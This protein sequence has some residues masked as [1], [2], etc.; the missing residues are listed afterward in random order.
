MSDEFENAVPIEEVEPLEEN[1]TEMAQGTNESTFNEQHDEPEEIPSPEEV[2]DKPKKKKYTDIYSNKGKVLN[3]NRILSVILFIFV[4]FILFFLFILPIFKKEKKEQV[5]LDKA[6]KTYIPEVISMWEK[7]T[8]TPNTSTTDYQTQVFDDNISDEELDAIIAEIPIS[9][10]AQVNTSTSSSTSSATSTRPITN[11]NPVQKQVTRMAW[12]NGSLNT[13]SSLIDSSTPI[14]NTVN[15]L[16]SRTDYMNSLSGVM[17][18]NANQNDYAAF[19]NQSDKQSFFNS[20]N[21]TE[22][23]YQWNSA[24][25]LFKGSILNAVL[26]TGINSDLPGVVIARVTKNVYSSL[27]GSYLLIPAGSRLFATYNSSI[28]IGQSRVQVSWNTLIRPDGLEYNL[29]NFTGVDTKGYAGYAGFVDE[30]FFEYAKAMGIVSLFSIINGGLDNAI[31][32]MPENAYTDQLVAENRTVVNQLSG[33]LLERTMNIQPT[34]IIPQGKEVDIITNRTINFPPL[35]SY[36][37][38]NTYTR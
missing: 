37:V 2:E 10:E 21:S 7:D 38:T 20:N 6:G 15:T 24:Y 1:F 16:P 19:N 31:A 26:E 28:S 13:G 25:S 17:P 29:G 23:S 18:S 36:P 12:N 35:E 9:D 32:R 34:I 22:G 30:N 3:R 5:S 4:F 8:K 27:D 33:S 14:T 11:R